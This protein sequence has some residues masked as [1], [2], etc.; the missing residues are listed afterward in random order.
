MCDDFYFYK[1]KIQFLNSIVFTNVIISFFL[2]YRSCF[3]FSTYMRNCIY[4]EIHNENI[5]FRNLLKK[6][7]FIFTQ[8]NHHFY[9][10][11]FSIKI[12]N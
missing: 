6:T 8:K 12:I 3:V 1:Y 9:V 4:K 5:V 11:L 2:N 10:L 7:K